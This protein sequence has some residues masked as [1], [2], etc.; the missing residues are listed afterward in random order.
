MLKVSFDLSEFERLANLFHAAGEQAPHAVRRGL[1]KAGDKARTQMKRA[2]TKQTGLKAGVI[3]RALKTRRA[4]FGSLSYT[5]TSRGGDIS[6]KHF[7]AR[8]TRKGVSAAPRGQRAVFAGTFIKGGL[9]PD[10]KA[11]K[12]GGHV[13]ARTGRGRLPIEKQKSGVFIP[14]EMVTGATAAGFYEVANRHLGD[15]IAR[16][17][18]AILTG[19]A[20]RGR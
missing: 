3:A 5:I 17:L 6:L 12:M 8:E 16:E 18:L 10:R 4:S 13:F 11:L 20:P 9:F 7:G 1:N 2:L 15:D 19:A 14:V